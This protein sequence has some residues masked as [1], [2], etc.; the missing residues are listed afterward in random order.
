MLALLAAAI[1]M[2]RISVAIVI[3]VAVILVAVFLI[4]AVRR[5]DVTNEFIQY[6]S[7]NHSNWKIAGIEGDG[8]WL[9]FTLPNSTE[10][11]RFNLSNLRERIRVQGARSASART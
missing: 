10:P 8:D 9:L 11:L 4:L 6:I 7:R 1:S 2:Q 3:A 5:A